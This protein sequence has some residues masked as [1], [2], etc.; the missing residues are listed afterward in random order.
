M[1]TFKVVSDYDMVNMLKPSTLKISEEPDQDMEDDPNSLFHLK[2]KYTSAIT[3][4]F[5]PDNLELLWLILDAD[6]PYFNED[7][8]VINANDLLPPY[9]ESKLHP[10]VIV[11]ENIP[12]SSSNVPKKE[13]IEANVVDSPLI[14]EEKRR[15]QRIEERLNAGKDEPKGKG[16]AIEEPPKYKDKAVMN[17]E[18]SIEK[19]KETILLATESRIQTTELKKVLKEA[20][21]PPPIASVEQFLASNP[22]F[23]LDEITVN[24]SI[25][26]G[27]KDDKYVKLSSVKVAGKL[28]PEFLNWELRL[29]PRVKTVKNPNNPNE[30]LEVITGFEIGYRH[31]G[32]SIWKNVP[33]VN[34]P[35]RYNVGLQT[36][37]RGRPS[38]D[39][40][41]EPGYYSPNVVNAFMSG[42]PKRY[43]TNSDELREYEHL[44]NRIVRH[45]KETKPND[46]K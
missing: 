42:I 39:A 19:A 34:E 21:K 12:S 43:I 27:T 1:A 2:F 14:I 9:E 26:Y 45:I 29:Q 40:D 36:N 18:Q 25:R 4:N 10:P 46:Y 37:P 30:K 15:L 32:V 38:K 20:R 33:G 6:M 7:D 24:P 16:K 17:E 35:L 23:P 28:I 11:T 8:E 5:K 22:Q 13:N 41:R 31:T 44:V 3:Y